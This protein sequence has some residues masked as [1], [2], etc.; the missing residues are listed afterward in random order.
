MK[1]TVSFQTGEQVLCVSDH[2]RMIN[3]IQASRDQTMVV[4]ASK[5]NT[6]KVIKKKLFKAMNLQKYLFTLDE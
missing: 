2:K 3:D 6:A 4:T 5:D 1:F